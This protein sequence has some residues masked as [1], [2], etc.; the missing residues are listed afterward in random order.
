MKFLSKAVLVATLGLAAAGTAFAD[1][2]TLNNNTIRQ[3]QS[4][5][6]NR[7]D[8]EVGVV[9]M[10]AIGSGRVTLTNNRITQTQRGDDN[11]QTAK[12]GKIDKLSGNHTVSMS[13]NT[14]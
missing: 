11:R 12:I 10:G 3:D 9:D 5:N 7:Q 8:L 13:G 4:G 14:I 1:T 6:R 2:A